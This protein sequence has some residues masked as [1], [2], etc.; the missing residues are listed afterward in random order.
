MTGRPVKR[1]LTLR[2]HRTSVSLEEAFWRAFR[3]IAAEKGLPINALAA[4]V[5]EARA[6][7]VGLASAIRVF[8][9]AHYR[10]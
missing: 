9:L 6:P 1:S 10:G 4:E 7:D 8:V 2:G 5:D 3:D